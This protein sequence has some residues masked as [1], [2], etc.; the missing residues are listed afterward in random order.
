[1]R[2][3]QT[4]RAPH[5]LISDFAGEVEC[6]TL[7]GYFFQLD[8]YWAVSDYPAFLPIA[9]ELRCGSD[10]IAV[11]P[12]HAAHLADRIRACIDN[13]VSGSIIGRPDRDSGGH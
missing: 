13:C 11:K 5:M 3:A 8:L 10:V 4:N 9:A 1:M 7:C 2:D 6:E 12:D